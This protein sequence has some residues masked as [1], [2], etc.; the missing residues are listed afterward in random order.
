M[1][2]FDILSFIGG[3]SLFIFGMNVMGIS[4]ER[5][6]GS[7]L[8]AILSKLTSSPI[9]GLILGAAVTAVIQSSSAT[10]VMAIGFVN[11][12]LMELIQAV[13]IIIGA[14]LGTTITPWLLSLTG[15]EGSSIFIQLLK[16]TSF[17]PILALIGV[18]LLLASKRDKRRSIGASL[19]GFA[20]L[21]FG[22]ETMSEAVKPLA[23][24]EAFTNLFVLFSN[25]IIGVLVGIFVTAA[26]Q[27]SS[28]SIGILQALT[29]TGSVNMASAIPIIMGQ[30]IGTCVTALISS[31]GTNKNAKRTALVHLY[32][33]LFGTAAA[34]II[35]YSLKMI[36]GFDLSVQANYFSIAIIHTAFNLFCTVILFPFSKQL[37]RLAVLTVPE[38][39]DKEETLL[40]DERMLLTPAIAAA[41]SRNAVCAMAKITNKT[42]DYACR[43]AESFDEK[44]FGKTC[45]LE[46]KTD[47]FDDALEGYLARLSACELSD[48]DS[49]DVFLL[50]RSVTE[51]E[52]LAD[53]ARNIAE[54][55]Q[56]LNEKKQKFSETG[57]REMNVLISA[58]REVTD[59]AVSAF[60][61][62]ST[63]KARSVEPLEEVVDMLTKELRSRHIKRL[64]KAECG[65]T[66]G[67]I[68]NDMLT[69]FERVSDYC[70]NIA[71]AVLERDEVKLEPHDYSKR[72]K[73][74]NDEQYNALFRYYNEKYDL[75]K[76]DSK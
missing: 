74:G 68:V 66:S 50:L 14:N 36:F 75:N 25:P 2:I 51:F 61:E 4:L 59:T 23:E 8:K 11:S 16:P 62:N 32:F 37:A 17:A 40:L 63:E 39:K 6:A 41:Q 24:V 46:R 28:A 48:S 9:K 7:R 69:D 76:T 3:L 21:M 44:T 42:V 10:T 73:K 72:L 60:C 47:K 45:E 70:S 64:A 56:E 31:V 1:S 67:F 55:A 52:R 22:M 65:V 34:M 18:V 33:N 15:L 26:V 12:G 58:V 71:L 35:F 5:A 29:V 49:R 30:N 13:G 53:H 57:R 20:V 43:L 54:G 38:G 27:S 19:L